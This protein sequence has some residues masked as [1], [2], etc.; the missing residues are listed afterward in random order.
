[1][2]TSVA[3]IMAIVLAVASATMLQAETIIT[4]DFDSLTPDETIV[5]QDGWVAAFGNTNAAK[6]LMVVEGTTQDWISDQGLLVTP[7]DRDCMIQRADVIADASD[8]IEMSYTLPGL[9]AGFVSVAPMDTDNVVL[10]FRFG[11]NYDKWFIRQGDGTLLEAAAGLN[12]TDGYRLVLAID[13]A[14][15]EGEGEGS[16]SI[17]NLTTS[18]SL[19]PVTGLQDVNLKIPTTSSPSDWDGLFIRLTLAGTGLDSISYTIP[20]PSTLLLL[21][22]MSVL[23][24]GGRLRR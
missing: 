5:G 16:L 23:C 11:L 22:A 4:Y 10:P 12:G 14:A 18:G 13:L 24:L 21:I 20:E 15:N 8:L 17:Q 6:Y 1:M 3:S 7:L 2:R 19:T 9:T